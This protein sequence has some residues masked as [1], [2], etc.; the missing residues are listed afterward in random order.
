M[1]ALRNGVF[2][3]CIAVAMAC[4][5][6]IGRSSAATQAEAGKAASDIDP[7]APVRDYVGPSPKRFAWTAV[8][9]AE[10]YEIE[11][12]TDIDIVVFTHES[13]REPVLAMP[14]DF[15]LTAGTYFWRVTAHRGGR[16]IGDSGRSAFVVKDEPR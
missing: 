1:G 13:L 8:S 12:S 2:V 4:T 5:A 6:P 15:A 7:V 10:H 9:G 3:A 14:D 11:L 16:I